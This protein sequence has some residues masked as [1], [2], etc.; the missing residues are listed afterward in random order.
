MKILVADDDIVYRTL[1]EGLLSQWG[2]DVAVAPNGLE[3]WEVIKSDEPPNIAI[4]DW[5]MPEMDGFELCRKVREDHT[6]QNLYLLLFTGSY[7]KQEIIKV[8]VVG[9]DDYLIKP[10]EQLDLKMRLRAASRIIELQE[11]VER[12]KRSSKPAA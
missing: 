9:A 3:A 11:E 10:F 8:L 2:Y 7:K 4:V 1:M 5:M 12:L 6:I